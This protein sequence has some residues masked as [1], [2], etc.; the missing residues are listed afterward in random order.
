VVVP[1]IENKELNTWKKTKEQ[2][3]AGLVLIVFGDLPVLILLGA[4]G[5]IEY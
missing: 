5:V 4:I 3:A 1:K 2:L